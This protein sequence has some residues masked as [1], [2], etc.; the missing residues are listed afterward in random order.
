MSQRYIIGFGN[1]AMNDDGIGLR[2]VE[3]IAEQQLDKDFTVVEVGNDGMQLLTY[4]RDDVEKILIIDCAKMDMPAAEYLIFSPD[5]VASE[6][7][8]RNISTHE[9]DV[10]KL[11]KLGKELDCPIPE[12]RILA[13][14]P[15]SL[16][17]DMTLSAELEKRLHDYVQAAVAEIMK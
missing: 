3:A 16:E 1:Y 13:I 12:I 14:E 2:I 8:V 9:G 5:D 4:F 6:K 17:M 10:I 11:I 15:A 7:V